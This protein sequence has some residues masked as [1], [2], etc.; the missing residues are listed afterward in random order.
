[1]AA[2]AA[3]APPG[4]APRSALID[5]VRMHY[6][7]GGHGERVVVLLH[8]WPESWY[9]W[10]ETMPALAVDHTVLAVDL[11]GLGDSRGPVPSFDKRTLARFVHRLVAD[12]LGY[13]HVHLVGHDFGAGVAFA[14]AAFHRESVASLTLMDFP[15]AGPAVDERQLRAQLWWF[16]FHDVP[17]LPEQMVAMR[18]R[19]YLSWFYEHV[20]APPNRIEPRAV[21]EYVRTYCSAG[22][23][24]A[25]FELYRT[26]AT[27]T[28]DNTALTSDR[29]TLPILSM[30]A[31][32][33]ND[34]DADRAQLRQVVQPMAEGPISA[35]LVPGA[36]HFLPEE[37][38]E[39]VVAALR[40]FIDG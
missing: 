14:Y 21:N 27:D 31:A 38:P 23:L 18:Q 40:A 33:S 39:F 24:H 5:G 26:V 37:N 36:G 30:G 12:T 35:E 22:V 20:V 7:I 28:A 15:L 19:T 25:G 11:P 6:V 29:L 8:G 10:V 17:Q 4:F 9:E 32:R 13:Q 34:P 3:A 2:R 1:L 16:G